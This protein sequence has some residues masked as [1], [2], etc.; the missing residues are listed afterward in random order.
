MAKSFPKLGTSL[1]QNL[2]L[3]FSKT[4]TRQPF[5]R[6]G[7]ISKVVW[8]FLSTAFLFQNWSQKQQE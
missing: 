1:F 6:P 5:P 2:A 8:R 4:A 7:L 3:V